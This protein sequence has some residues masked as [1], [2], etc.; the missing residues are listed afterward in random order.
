M[1]NYV[2]AFYMMSI[3][4]QILKTPRLSKDLFSEYAGVAKFKADMHNVFIQVRADDKHACWKLPYVVT[5]EDILAVVQ[6]WPIEWMKDAGTKPNIPVP[7][8][9]NVGAGPSQTQQQEPPE[10]STEQSESQ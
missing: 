6:Q 1:T 8:V 2:F 9:T 5:Q 4:Y 7:L 10:D 3:S